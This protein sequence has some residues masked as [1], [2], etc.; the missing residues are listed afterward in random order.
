LQEGATMM[1]NSVR[2][3][4]TTEVSPAGGTNSRAA[5]KLVDPFH[6]IEVVLLVRVDSLTIV[7][8]TARMIRIPYS[9]RC[10]DSLPGMDGL[11]GLRI[12]PRFSRRVRETVGGDCGCPYL[13]DLVLQACKFVIV[14][15]GA[16]RAR[17]AVLG[18]DDL[19]KFSSIRQEM[20]QCAGH[21]NLPDK[22]LPEWLEH[23]RNQNRQ[24]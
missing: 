10:R 4:I 12:G 9:D 6:E 16:Q 5:A 13:V 20:G 3:T 15:S 22:H 23:E 18:E 24:E 21:H 11:K 19:E 17:D 8:A 14:V 1:E 2:R 7:E